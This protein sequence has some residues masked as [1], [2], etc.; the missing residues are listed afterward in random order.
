MMGVRFIAV[1]DGY[2]SLNNT[3]G[4]EM[5]VP[6]KNLINDAYSKVNILGDIGFAIFHKNTEQFGSEAEKGRI[7]R[8]ICAKLPYQA[9]DKNQKD[10]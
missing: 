3:G 9:A 6:F 5:M 10:L 4:S 8:G 2:D 1:T 7:H